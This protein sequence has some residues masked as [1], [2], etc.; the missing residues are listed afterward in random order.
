M[1]ERPSG[2]RRPRTRARPVRPAPRGDRSSPAGAPEAPA[3][4]LLVT[5]DPDLLDDLLR[6]AAAADV[7]VTV[8]HAAAHASREWPRAPLVVVGADLVAALADLEPDRHPNVVVAGSGSAGAP[9]GGRTSGADERIWNAA[10]RIGAREVLAVP[11]RET[12]LVDLFAEATE[13]GL[14]RARVVAVV[15]GRGGAGASLLAVAL[16][17]AGERARLRTLLVDADPLGSGLDLLIGEEHVTGTRWGELTARQ[18]RMSWPSLHGALPTVRGLTLL[19]WARGPAA[20]IPA[21]AMR[22]VLASAV[23]GT[24]LVVADLPRT[25]DA[26][27]HEVLRR[28]TVALLAVPADVH[29]VMSASRI[30]P[31]LRDHVADLRLVVRGA[32]PAGLPADAVALSLGLPLAG[33]LADEPGIDRALERGEPPAAR[34]RSPLAA[35]GDAFVAR[36]RTD[37]AR[38][39]PRRS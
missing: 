32:S 12:R 18:G 22:A 21:P 10:L 27:A 33:E 24:D 2:P 14:E 30:A 17:L 31:M 7:E 20:R 1:D 34:P 8:A 26:T 39:P 28:T 6:L 25:L 36:L 19:T 16:A 15:G 38:P 9:T 5:D 13:G 3:R 4:P 23:R 35:F 29:A 11:E 37:S